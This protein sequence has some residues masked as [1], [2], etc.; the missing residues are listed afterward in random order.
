MPPREVMVSSD[1]TLR[2]SI[3][4]MNLEN[5]DHKWMKMDA[6]IEEITETITA[7]D[8]A[9]NRMANDMNEMKRDIRKILNNLSLELNIT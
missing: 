9:L 4:N 8:D 3:Q 1:Q 7:H 2:G 5:V 6:V